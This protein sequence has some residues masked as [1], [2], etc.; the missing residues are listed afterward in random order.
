MTTT[1]A[2]VCE[3]LI[4]NQ[5]RTFWTKASIVWKWSLDTVFEPSIT[6]ARSI[7]AIALQTSQLP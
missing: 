3:L 5:L 2:L 4:S 1:A 6:K 7:L